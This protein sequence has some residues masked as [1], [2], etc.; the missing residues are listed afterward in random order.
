MKVLFVHPEDDAHSGPWIQQKWDRVIDLGIGGNSTYCRWA[1]LFGCTVQDTK[2]SSI[3]PQPI[4]KALAYGVGHLCDSHGIDWWKVISIKYIPELYW[5]AALTAIKETIDPKDDIYFSRF[6]FD[7]RV[8][9]ELLGREAICFLRERTF[10]NKLK[11]DYQKL[12]R[13][14]VTQII[15]IMFDK[16]DSEHNARACIYSKKARCKEPQILLPTAY[17]NVT[18]MALA[19]ARSL[20]Q[21]K[22]LIVSARQTGKSTATIPNV[23]QAD[24]AAYSGQRFDCEEF[25]DL[26]EKWLRLR[27]RLELEPLLR[28]LLQTGVLN[29][30]S[31]DLH[32]WLAIRNMWMNV[33][34]SEPIVA[35]L[36][37]D[38]NNPYTSIPLLIAKQRGI[39]SIVCHHGALDGHCAVKS[40]PGDILLAKGHM[41]QD[42]LLNVG[43][44]QPA[45]IVVGAPAQPS[46][47]SEHRRKTVILFFSE[48]YETSGGR[49]KEFFRDLLP[50]LAS[51]ARRTGRSLVIKLH[52]AENL[53]ERHR[54]IRDV[55]SR[56]E[57]AKAQI[58]DGPF[59]EE[60]ISDAWCAVTVSSTVALDCSLRNVPVFLCSWLENWP[61]G[62][63]KQFAKFSVGT[64]LSPSDIEAIPTLVQRYKYPDSRDIWQPLEQQAMHDIVANKSRHLKAAV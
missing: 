6:S 18:R 58:I 27:R 11:G 36:S 2:F 63:S 38:D 59:T 44:V 62:Y 7:S 50:P 9:E 10:R 24:L 16:Y 28:V 51:V 55:L 22:F 3:T 23:A 5:I 8:F 42:Y 46:S 13:L 32:K 45:R 19:Y 14:S 25:K 43:G 56:E 53:R 31:K 26:H 48:D 12:R 57:M 39:P 20:P 54:I 47:F 52:P 4:R 60:L 30:F 37:C 15:Q 61:F 40:S 49:V 29:S 21:H 35:V 33:F 34:A 41:E 1:D 17:V 64:I